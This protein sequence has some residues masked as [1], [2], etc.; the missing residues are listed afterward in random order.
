MFSITAVVTA[1]ITEKKTELH[2]HFSF[3]TVFLGLKLIDY[4]S[5]LIDC[6]YLIEL[7]LYKTQNC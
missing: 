3:N 5:D 1:L 7:A 6:M 2:N 4:G